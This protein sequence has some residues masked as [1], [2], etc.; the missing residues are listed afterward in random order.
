M[1]INSNE[2]LINQ[3]NRGRLGV[4]EGVNCDVYNI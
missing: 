3:L 2:L 4:R 1:V